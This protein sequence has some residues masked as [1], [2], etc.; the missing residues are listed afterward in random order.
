MRSSLEVDVTGGGDGDKKRIEEVT[1]EFATIRC[2]RKEEERKLIC[3]GDDVVGR[4]VAA[5]IGVKE[6]AIYLFIYRVETNSK[7]QCVIL[8]NI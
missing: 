8:I 2:G 5:F 3:C 6:K 7:P 4:C 1:S